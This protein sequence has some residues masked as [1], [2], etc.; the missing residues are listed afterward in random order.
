MHTRSSPVS[1]LKRDRSGERL[2]DPPATIFEPQLTH[3]LGD[4]FVIITKQSVTKNPPD[5]AS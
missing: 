5:K 1:S 4:N 3:A 2:D